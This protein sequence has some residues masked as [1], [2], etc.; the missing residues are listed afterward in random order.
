MQMRSA[1]GHQHR[2]A[3]KLQHKCQ[4]H[5]LL[6]LIRAA[7][8]TAAAAERWL[9]SLIAFGPTSVSPQWCH[10]NWR[11]LLGILNANGTTR[12]YANSQI[13]NS[14]PGRLVAW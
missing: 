4:Q 2:P 3:L 9:A 14:R 12:R 11:S 6:T 8:L 1:A 10:P 7:G 13:A 5:A